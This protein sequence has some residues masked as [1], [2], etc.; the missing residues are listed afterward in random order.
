VHTISGAPDDAIAAEGLDGLKIAVNASGHEKCERCWHQREDVGS[1]SEHPSL[2]GRC[3][4]N[5]SGNP[6]PRSHA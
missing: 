5:I 4:G 1:N 6:E 2:C 3:A